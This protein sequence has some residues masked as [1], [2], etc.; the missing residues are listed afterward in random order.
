MSSVFLFAVVVAFT[1][2]FTVSENT[3][4][5]QNQLRE[6]APSVTSRLQQVKEMTRSP[7]TMKREREE[8]LL[9]PTKLKRSLPSN[10]NK[11]K[12]ADVDTK[13]ANEAISKVN[14]IIGRG[15]TSTELTPA[16]MKELETYARSNPDTWYA[17]A[18]YINYVFG[19]GLVVFLLCGMFYLGWALVAPESIIIRNT[20]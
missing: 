14:S 3:I 10:P 9:F 13:G 6:T 17:M 15:K 4:Q 8:W 2:G 11:L 5:K 16:K 7:S 20:Y 19:I 12:P 1:A 18:Y